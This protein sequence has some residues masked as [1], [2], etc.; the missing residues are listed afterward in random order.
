VGLE[1]VNTQEGIEGGQV[2]IE[3]RLAMELRE[4]I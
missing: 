2:F 1:T 3:M 4:K